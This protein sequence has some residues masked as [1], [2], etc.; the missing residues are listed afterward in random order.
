MYNLVNS[1]ISLE[2]MDLARN[3]YGIYTNNADLLNIKKMCEFKSFAE[4]Y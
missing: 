3:T 1:L 4:I 2:L